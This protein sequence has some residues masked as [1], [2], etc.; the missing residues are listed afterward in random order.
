MNNIDT[1]KIELL[2]SRK[3]NEYAEVVLTS[4]LRLLDN[5]KQCFK[6]P[7]DDVVTTIEGAILLLQE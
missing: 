6:I 3:R 4:L 7:F 1:L 2:D 5:D